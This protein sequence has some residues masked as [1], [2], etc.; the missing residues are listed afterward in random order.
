[1]SLD[2]RQMEI[3]RAIHRHGSVGQAARQLNL[4]QP[5]VSKILKRL[6]DALEVRLFERRARGMEPTPYADALAVHAE[7]VSSEMRSAAETIRAM[8]GL[9]KGRVRIGVTPSIA[10]GILPAAVNALLARHPG[11]VVQIAEGIEDHLL[12]LL[13]KGEADIL[14]CGSMRRLR[15]LPVTVETLFADRVCVICRPDHPLRLAPTRRLRD[16]LDYPWILTD[17]EN[18]MWRRLSDAFAEAGLEPPR[19]TIETGSAT[20]MKRLTESGDYLTYLSRVLTREE[21]ADG[22]LAAL[23]P[24]LATWNRD[25]VL[26]RRNQGTLSPPTRALI[27]ALRSVTATI[28]AA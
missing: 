10:S 28:E 12:P 11:L 20:F 24:S 17:T 13:L 2:L 19:A 16:L 15:A 5:A 14:V 4:T 1:M 3:F 22:R 8:R 18:V 26:V 25:L 21:E 6:E 9:A 7:L 23:D 27:D